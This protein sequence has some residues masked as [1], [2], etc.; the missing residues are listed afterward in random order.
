MNKI[1]RR[2]P[3]YRGNDPYIRAVAEY[4][5]YLHQTMDYLIGDLYRQVN[6]ITKKEA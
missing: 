6:E 2:P 5:Q 3:E 4:L 1:S